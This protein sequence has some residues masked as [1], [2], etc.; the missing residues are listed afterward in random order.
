M[1]AAT[2]NVKFNSMTG[3][4]FRFP[5]QQPPA[6]SYVLVPCSISKLFKMF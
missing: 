2:K 4:I 6:I 5:V 1:Y 3:N